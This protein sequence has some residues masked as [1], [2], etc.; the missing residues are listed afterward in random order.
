MNEKTPVTEKK[1][2]SHLAKKQKPEG[3]KD[4]S[5]LP[6]KKK[7]DPK[8]K[9]RIIII[10][11][12]V[13]LLVVLFFVYRACAAGS[14]QGSGLTLA[15]TTIL[16]YGDI[17][18]SFSTTGTVES[19]SSMSVYSTQA[20]T[21]QSV[22]VEVG[23]YVNEGQ[24]LCQLDGESIQKQ[25]DAQQAGKSDS[26]GISAEQIKSAQDSYNAAKSALEKGENASIISAQS[27]VDSALTG[28][29]AATDSYNR[30]RDS[31]S[32][33]TNA[34]LLQQE[35]AL[36]SAKAG[37]ETAQDSYNAALDDRTSAY[38]SWRE[39]E[40][41]LSDA[42]SAL[43]S[44]RRSKASI[45]SM[46]S[47]I[48][49]Y[50]SQIAVLKQEIVTD[51]DNKDV[52]EAKIAELNAA[53]AALNT[54]IT[55][56]GGITAVET[57]IAQQESTVST[58]RTKNTSLRS[59]YDSAVNR[60]NSAKTALDN[61]KESL[62]LANRQYTSTVNSV[63]NALADYATSVDTA[64]ES[65]Q[66]ALEA[67]QAAKTAAQNQLQSYAN[68]LG[69][70]Q[71][72]AAT[73]TTDVSIRNLRA[74]LSDTGI[75]APV[76]GTVTAVYAEVGKSGSGLLFII[77]DVE[78]LVVETTVKDY[79]V[80]SVTVGMPVTIKSDSTGSE[81]FD[82]AV[83]TVAP[84]AMK[85]A[86]GDTDTTSGAVYETEAQV[87]TKNSGLKIGM[88]A[89][90][91]FIVAQEENVL[92]V[93]YEAVYENAQGQTVILTAEE[94]KN[95]KFLLV[96][97]PVTTGMENDIDIVVTGSE[98]REGLRVVN[99]PENYA[100]LAGREIDIAEHRSTIQ[101]MMDMMGG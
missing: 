22:E 65:Y 87:L 96:E 77:E 12:V 34:T 32:D 78:Q 76:S 30:Y 18:D 10:V 13:V 63:D 98:V 14:A 35:A 11:T 64:Y 49:E 86:M 72:G 67:L 27:Q 23:D 91:N 37:L 88:S 56:L 95:G 70:A 39:G 44:L 84:A 29:N 43:S 50:N 54:Q 53:I 61:A 21:V 5:A 46:T 101:S 33:G 38:N 99:E 3:E 93:P 94:Q 31:L 4:R 15:D 25:I 24:L 45:V 6:V 83:T 85:N 58:L 51:P 52:Y 82:G 75:T 73:G 81:L 92:S 41:D 97:I 8:K 55:S 80:T 60:V 62:A 20:Y 100:Y 66:T 17:T 2:P 74:D 48:A 40:D 1:K 16:K 79:D 19:A 9:K 69:S 36:H 7:M 68:A 47:Q 90:L 57:K 59:A 71:A 26:Q 89:R 42:E 28:Y